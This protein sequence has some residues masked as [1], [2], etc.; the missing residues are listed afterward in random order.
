MAIQSVGGAAT[1]TGTSLFDAPK[2][3]QP[4]AQPALVKSVNQPAPTTPTA[5]GL[6]PKL[7]NLAQAIR[8][9]ESAGNFQAKGAS[10]EY[11][12]YQFM[13]DTWNG[14]A[15][16]F[17]VNV[18]LDQ[19]TPQQQNEVA[20]KQLQEWSQQHPEWNV[21]NFASAWNAGPG[22]P[23][24]Y[25]GNSGTNS[26]GVQYDTAAYAQ[27]VATAYQQYKAQGAQGATG[28]PTANGSPQPEESPSLLG[29]GANVLKSGANFLGNI[30]EAALHPIQTVQ[31]IGGAAVGALQEAGGQTTDETAKFDNLKNYFVSRYG[32][33]SN[34]ESTIYQDPVGF[35]SD[36]S[37]VLGTG[38]GIAGAVGKVGK[39]S[40][41]AD[42]GAASD[43]ALATGIRTMAGDQAIGNSLT[44][45]ASATQSALSTGAKFTNPLTL[46][47]AAGGAALNKAGNAIKYG[48]SQV[49][50]L[51][52]ETISS[53]LE[54]PQ[55]FTP[56]EI[57]NASRIGIARDIEAS[58][59]NKDSELSETGRSYTPYKESPTSLTVEADFLDNALRKHAGVDVTDGVI[60]GTSSS[61]VRDAADIREL[62]DIYN[63]YKPDFL[64]G[65][66]DSQKFLNL[67]EDLSKTANFNKGL[68]KDIQF[69]ARNIRENLNTN[70]RPQVK[71]LEEKDAA[72]TAQ[73]PELDKLRK[74]FIDKEG[75]LLESAVNKI[76][77]ATGKGK[78][79]TLDRL[80]QIMP[81][82]TKRLQ[83]QKAIE[84]IQKA[85][86]NKEGALVRS[87]EPGGAVV[88]IATG[89]IGLAAGAIAALILQNPNIAVPLIKLF[90]ANKDLAAAVTAKLAKAANL[91]SAGNRAQ[92]ASSEN[93]QPEGQPSTQSPGELASPQ[94]SPTQL[95]G[96]QGKTQE[97]SQETGGQ[98]LSDSSLNSLASNKRF[99]LAAARASGYSDQEIQDFLQK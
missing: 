88:A 32:G 59:A 97:L 67:R 5:G 95:G 98:I 77:N 10:G 7:V 33:V 83:I 72:Y 23:D 21:G 20:Y 78:D 13:P 46:P 17:G 24:A 57:A 18:P 11:G 60:K 74:G 70:Y 41:V 19:A 8:Q 48:T 89:H 91:G 39:L 42:A 53:I 12:A 92:Q 28:G 56:E 96:S 73:K 4:T 80:E 93:G 90:G 65:T 47:I 44:R 75:N 99:D 69:A 14:N 82:I 52:G 64:N 76:A 30:G 34:L 87:L 71:G 45:G 40:S 66:M 86:G 55:K 22:K 3:T 6:D 9:T 79:L 62:Q 63:R 27:K 29:F 49:T 84:D 94:G 43:A 25:L 51:S 35:L 31:N 1:N 26:K 38:A 68:S 2:P 54:N 16:R 15:P 85:A 37:A 50:G 61:G 58:L 81:G 36:L